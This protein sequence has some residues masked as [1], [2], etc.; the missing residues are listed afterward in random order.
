M[1]ETFLASLRFP[2]AGLS[3]STANVFSQKYLFWSPHERVCCH[4]PH[5]PLF[6]AFDHHAISLN[7]WADY[8]SYGM[9]TRCVRSCTSNANTA[10]DAHSVVSALASDFDPFTNI[11][12]FAFAELRCL[13]VGQHTTD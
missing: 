8:T 9:G 7:L 3:S 13:G 10:A 2:E 12:A 5:C 1:C 11:L 4:P 6:L